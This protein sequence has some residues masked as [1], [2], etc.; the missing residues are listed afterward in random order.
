[1]FAEYLH[2]FFQKRRARRLNLFN[3]SIQY[4]LREPKWDIKTIN[5]AAPVASSSVDSRNGLL[6]PRF[7]EIPDSA[8]F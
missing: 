4:V 6:S 2:C 8:R 7:P 1:F 3:A 5:L